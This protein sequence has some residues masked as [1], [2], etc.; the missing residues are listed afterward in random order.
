MTRKRG[1]KG[2]YENYGGSEVAEKINGKD[3]GVSLANYNKTYYTMLPQ[4]SGRTKRQWLGKDLQNAI[5]RFRAIV[6]ELK[7]EKEVMIQTTIKTATNPHGYG[8]LIDWETGEDILH[9]FTH[10]ASEEQYIQW[11]KKEL[12][13]PQE[14]AKKTGLDAF[15]RFYEY[16]QQEQILRCSMND[17]HLV[18]G[19]NGPHKEMSEWE[20]R[21]GI[22]GNFSLKRRN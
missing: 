2:D 3:I 6:A 14:L 21:S 10:P 12:Q 8:P 7:G 11:L 19:Y 20:H 13:N 5:L 22:A 9:E 15:N 1:R 16:I 18:G 17:G 4:K